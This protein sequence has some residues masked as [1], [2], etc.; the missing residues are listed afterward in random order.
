MRPILFGGI[1]DVIW[2]AHMV[3]VLKIRFPYSR[4]T[5]SLTRKEDLNE[6]RPVTLNIQRDLGVDLSLNDIIAVDWGDGSPVE[7]ITDRNRANVN[8]TYSIAKSEDLESKSSSFPIKIY[9]RDEKP[10]YFPFEKKD[11]NPSGYSIE[12]SGVKFARKYKEKK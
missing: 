3:F 2:L 5:R 12:T 10:T 8:H 4:N 7:Y 6:V 1:P 9:V 11:E